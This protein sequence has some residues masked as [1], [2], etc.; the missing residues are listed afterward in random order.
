MTPEQRERFKKFLGM[1][2]G[3][4]SRHANRGL[5][6]DDQ[7]LASA[8]EWFDAEMAGPE[9][10]RIMDMSAHLEVYL[11]V[12]AG[13]ADKASASAMLYDLHRLAFVGLVHLRRT[14]I[15]LAL[16]ERDSKSP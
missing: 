7:C 15:E 2:D 1:S 13:P 9:L 12:N 16:A 4:V 8:Q 5:A 11:N 14:Y 3:E 10:A 6:Y